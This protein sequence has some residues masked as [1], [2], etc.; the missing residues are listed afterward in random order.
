MR[1][2]LRPW[3]GLVTLAG[4]HLAS[5]AGAADPILE[6]LIVPPR[7][8]PAACSLRWTSPPTELSA[9]AGSWALFEVALAYWFGERTL[10][11]REQL[12]DALLSHYAPR[13][14]RSD[15]VRVQVLALAFAKEASAVETE[16]LLAE[17][18]EGSPIHRRARNG[19]H[20]LLFAARP[21]AGDACRDAVWDELRDR[22]QR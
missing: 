18:I 12:T 21:T 15:E 16:A 13:W 10:P 8:L 17:R 9:G 1:L 3:L 19:R 20:L 14:G 22:L 2:G 6:R 4:L 11:P 5:P 7:E